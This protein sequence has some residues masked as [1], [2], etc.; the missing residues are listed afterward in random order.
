MKVSSILFVLSTVAFTAFGGD[1]VLSEGW[2][3]SLDGSAW[4]E[5]EVPHDWAIAGPFDANSKDGDT[6]KLP[7]R[8]IGK[9]RKSFVVQNR[10]T[11]GTVVLDF[12]GVM[13]R[14][15]VYVNGMFAGGWD[16]GYQSFRVDATP[17]VRPGTNLLEVV[18]DTRR[19]RSR[20]YPGGGINRKVVLRTMPKAHFVYN[21]I[22][23]TTPVAE[24]DRAVVRVRWEATNAVADAQVKV[25]LL[26]DGV[27]KGCGNVLASKGEVEI[28]LLN[29][30]LWDVVSPRLYQAECTLS[31]G[32]ETVT[33]R[34]RFGIRKIEFPVG[35]GADTGI[36]EK[37]GFHLNG[38]RVQLKGVNLHED[39]GLLG[40][41]YCR[42]AVRRQ[43]L[44]M[45]DMGA[46]ALRTSHNPVA[47]ETLDLCDELGI[48]VW[49]E[50]FD[51]WDD[52]A[53]RLPEEPLEPYVERN[54]RAFVRRDRN[55]PSVI[56]WSMGNEIGGCAGDRKD[57]THDPDGMTRERCARFRDAMRSEDATRPIGNGN[58]PHVAKDEFFDMGIWDDLDITGWNYLGSH[59]KAKAKY[60][61]K[62]IIYSESASAGSTFGFYAGPSTRPYG[63]RN[64]TE[65][66]AK[67]MDSYDLGTTI[68]IADIEFD[69]MEK[70]PWCAGEF[71][72]TGIDYL[73]EPIPFRNDARSS[74]FGIV[75][76]TGVPKDRYWL[77]R[78][79]WNKDADTVHVLP[80]WNWGNGER[81]TG[82]G[83]RVVPVF[84]Y[85][86]GDA[87]ELFI[88]GR[89]QGM[90]R[91]GLYDLPGG[92]TNACYRVCGNYRLMW[93]D[94]AYEPGE[95]KAVAYRNGKR[96]GESVVRTAG[97]PVALKL[98]SDYDDEEM[99]F[100]QIDAV[101]LADVRNPL[102]TNRVSL[103]VAGPGCIVGVGNGNPR[104]YES[105]TDISTHSLFFGK[106]VAVVR[107]KGAGP[108]VLSAAAEDLAPAK[109]TIVEQVSRQ[110]WPTVTPETKPAEESQI[111]PTGPYW[112]AKVAL[113][114]TLVR[115]FELAD[116]PIEARLQFAG[117]ITD[118][119]LDGKKITHNGY[120]R[121]RTT[122]DVTPSM[123]PGRHELKLSSNS[124]ANWAQWVQ[125]ELFL[126]FRDGRTSTICLEDGLPAKLTGSNPVLPP[127]EGSI[128]LD[129]TD[130]RFPQREISASVEPSVVKGGETLTFRFDFVGAHLPE[131]PFEAQLAYGHGD[132][133]VWEERL[134]A[135]RDMVT[136]HGGGKWTLSVK[137]KA[138]RYMAFSD[139]KVCLKAFALYRVGG[140]KQ[141]ATV[142]VER[143]MSDVEFPAPVTAVVTNVAGLAQIALNGKPAFVF[144]GG[145]SDNRPDFTH[146]HSDAPI[147]VVTVGSC[148]RRSW[149]P[150]ADRFDFD[151]LDEGAETYARDVPG[152][153]FAI[154]LSVYPPKDWQARHPDEMS[155]DEDGKICSCWKGAF[156]FSSE[157]ALAAMEH[158]V[159]SAIRH[160]ESSPYANRVIA[161]RINSGDTIEWLG[162]R[163]DQRGKALDFSPAGRQGF[164]AWC[165]T[166]A[167]EIVGSPV[168]RFAERTVC[169]G[170]D[171][172]WEIREH[173]AVVAYHRY[174]S[175]AIANA[176]IRLC[177]KAKS[178]VGGRKLVGTYY[179][180]TMTLLSNCCEQSKGHFSLRKVIDSGAVDFLMS[181]QSYSVRYLGEPIGDM[182]PF[183]TLAK[184]GIVP[185]IEDDTRTSVGLMLPIGTEAQGQLQT[186]EQTIGVCRRNM[187][188][189][190]C[191]GQNPYFT[192][193]C[194]GTEFDF[195]QFGQDAAACCN[196]GERCLADG[197]RRRA[198][199]AVVVSEES[200]KAMPVLR[201][202][203]GLSAENSLHYNRDGTIRMENCGGAAIFCESFCHIYK[204]L[205]TLGTSVDYVLAE[206]LARHPGDYRLYVFTNAFRVDEDFR[207]TVEKLRARGAMLL[208]MLAPGYM[209]ERGNSLASM[210][211]L[212]GFSFEKIG[213][214]Q[215]ASATMTDGRRMGTHNV[216]VSPLF[217]VIDRDAEVL[218][219]WVDGSVAVAAKGT[220]V[221]CGTFQTDRKFLQLLTQRAGVHV[222]SE[223]G[224]PLEANERLVCLHAATAGQKT[225]RLPR[226]AEEVY[227]VFNRKVVARNVSEFSFDAPLHST[228]LFA[229]R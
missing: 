219:R 179:G 153:Y 68:D 170:E 148:R 205:A 181:P 185:L 114:N 99:C 73:G 195:P 177:R 213:G 21:G 216:P 41:A 162:W 197:V 51:K 15:K 9:Y 43:L 174:E 201:G 107:R 61:A 13:A 224:D 112:R 137:T 57:F 222:Y 178:L 111:R 193:L 42:S 29:P 89:S 100:V 65:S 55:H 84:V 66:V 98:T 125:G 189:A 36:W 86:S 93:F 67:Q 103:S 116:R 28:E 133:T 71:V 10:D 101:D 206:D 128:R 154:D 117:A 184:N 160:V 188:F 136:E 79:Y 3:F 18:A 157:K 165:A 63:Y 138:P 168:P 60:P 115:A 95:V 144:A 194:S 140:K 110:I 187:G 159:E 131:F 19:H 12:D 32:S 20:W 180:Y 91:K 122:W 53:S 182:K 202:F 83:E 145:V 164:A 81:G 77:Y 69:R 134:V 30:Q 88:N 58:M 62:P 75:D 92:R 215:V 152:A 149:W 35:V 208:W 135:T 26:S 87:A 121:N 214:P 105:F 229:F 113:T 223:T 171:V 22:A 176:L 74:Y 225:I 143:A 59:E 70:S 190:L 198:E 76:L 4:R 207:R 50:C 120:F 204:R 212:T 126:R 45:K 228:W 147:N 37:N 199:I 141:Y 118:V 183:A 1:C 49:D 7:W 39:M 78:A 191:R 52:T 24:K 5:V 209:D 104:A 211:S 130:Y 23:I 106:A 163:P 217:R 175:D 139:A 64:G 172:F 109:I 124:K 196:V 33:E 108:I 119:H 150:A 167:P 169:R 40:R 151:A 127:Y 96:I 38:R 142:T 25:R 220:D 94:T 8:G 203:H 129:Y 82:N 44:L 102:A 72:W 17:F 210:K 132:S 47:P 2:K 166:N 11:A 161:Y 31:S 16:Y 90:R 34:V 56:V 226:K 200:L 155:T 192:A 227:D 156:S 14:P 6:G 218:G 80:H 146:R 54:L 27:E 123:S 48:L 221:F 173:P 85:T 46:N 97:K 158:A 186:L